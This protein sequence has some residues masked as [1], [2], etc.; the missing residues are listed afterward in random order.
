MHSGHWLSNLKADPL[1]WLL[2]GNEPVVRWWT[3]RD[4]L[5][6]LA[7]DL[8]V[9]AA[10]AAARE[11]AAARTILAAQ[12]RGGAWVAEKHL[13]S[14]KHTAT[15]WQL[16]L[17]ADFGF[18]IA[19]EPVRRACHLFLAW[20]LPSGAF[21]LVAKAIAGEACSTG[22]ILCQFHRFGLGDD[23]QVARAWDWLATTQRADGGW[24]CRA[25]IMRSAKPSCFL[26]TVK[27][28]EACRAA[29]DTASDLARGAAGFVHGCLM[30]PR[31]ERYTS[32]TL[33]SRFVYPNHWYDAL[34]VVD[35]LVSFGYG[36]GDERMQAAVAL[37]RQKQN[38]DG[39]WNHDSE[40]AFRGPTLYNFGPVG[41]PSPWVTFRALRAVKRYEG[42]R[43]SV[44]RKSGA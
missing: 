8:E 24:H 25:A 28:L 29:G 6:R 38:A 15:T 4:L 33:W 9:S 41:A 43:E 39:T 1:P 7:T 22:R 42:I 5:D 21:G 13:Y 30:E 14:P 17:L 36:A 11:S 32:P 34:S 18:T 23:P 26:A 19:D 10:Y 16:D 2:S 20:Q 37:I 44:I 27:V 12:R 3:L 35:L 40:L 31:I